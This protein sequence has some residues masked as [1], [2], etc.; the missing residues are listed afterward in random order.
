MNID[1]ES[2]HRQTGRTNAMLAQ[3]VAWL[4]EHPTENVAVLAV[5]LQDCQVMEL[6]WAKLL[7]PVE[8]PRIQFLNYQ[9]PDCLRGVQAHIF[10]DHR[11]YEHLV[12]SFMLRVAERDPLVDQR[13]NDIGLATMTYPGSFEPSAARV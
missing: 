1:I 10:V 9:E 8:L 13:L 11:V 5:D 6:R 3:A 2:A 12:M 7:A 4:R